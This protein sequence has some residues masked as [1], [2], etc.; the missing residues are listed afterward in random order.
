LTGELRRALKERGGLGQE[1]E[2]IVR[3]PIN[4]TDAQ[5]QDARNYEPGMVLEF[6]Q[7]I[8]GARHRANGK[9]ETTGG[10]ERGAKAVVIQGGETVW[11]Q[12][13]DGTRA[14]LPAEQAAR[15]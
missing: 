15:F 2:F 11:L 14:V 3:R 6:H 12:R 13:Q 10:F 5:K 9:R 4:W 8:P 7:A 1:R